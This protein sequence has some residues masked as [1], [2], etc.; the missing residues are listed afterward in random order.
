MMH[1]LQSFI[2]QKVSPSVLRNIKTSMKDDWHRSLES[3]T[4]MMN[5]LGRGVSMGNWKDFA[6]REITLEEI[7][8]EDI[9]RVAKLIFHEKNMT[10]THV[11][12]AKSV[13][14]SLTSTEMSSNDGRLSLDMLS[15]FR[16]LHVRLC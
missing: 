5:E 10:I 11:I 3:V 13:L 12:P 15:M 2:S 1:V 14:N 7:T 6:D 8:P 9:Q 16:R 4:D